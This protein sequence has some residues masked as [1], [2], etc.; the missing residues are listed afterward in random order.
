VA[1]VCAQRISAAI[2]FER[3]IVFVHQLH[4]HP[5]VTQLG[6]AREVCHEPSYAVRNLAFSSRRWGNE[7]FLWCR[8]WAFEL[9]AVGNIRGDRAWEVIGGCPFYCDILVQTG[10]PEKELFKGY[11]SAVCC[12]STGNGASR[13]FLVPPQIVPAVG[14]STIGYGYVWSVSK[15]RAL[16]AF[17]RI[18]PTQSFIHTQHGY[19]RQD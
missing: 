16:L 10:I 13:L 14:T 11:F 4:T 5:A 12:V 9:H 1:V 7:G 8:R 17:R 19:N 15:N 18:P 2:F 6:T 3:R